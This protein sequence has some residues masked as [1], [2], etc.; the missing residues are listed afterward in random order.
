MKPHRAIRTS[1]CCQTIP[2]F[3]LVVDTVSHNFSVFISISFLFVSVL[4]SGKIY[5]RASIPLIKKIFK[6]YSVWE[7]RHMPHICW[8]Y[9]LKTW[10]RMSNFWKNQMS[11]CFGRCFYT[12]CLELPQGTSVMSFMWDNFLTITLASL[13]SLAFSGQLGLPQALYHVL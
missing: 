12:N 11:W 1:K 4:I 7:Q 5:T 2:L 9:Y 6:F 8:I 13:M 10:W 3:L